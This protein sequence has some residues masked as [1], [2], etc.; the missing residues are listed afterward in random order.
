[1]KRVYLFLAYGFE[2]VE[3]LTAVDLLRRAGIQVIT[4]SV[5][6]NDIVMGA[7][8]IPVVADIKIDNGAFG[9]ADAFIKPGG[10]P[11]VDKL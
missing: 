7:H 8:K 2:E 5:T 11:G 1:M 9:D 3:A 6:G 4:V 10:Q